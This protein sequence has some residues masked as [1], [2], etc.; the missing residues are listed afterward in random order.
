[1]PKKSSST[2]KLIDLD[3]RLK[4][5]L[6]DYQNLKKR[7]EKEKQAYQKFV[8]A[9]ILDKFLTVLDDLQRAYQHLKDPGLKLALDQFISTLESEGV[10]EIKLLNT[11]FDPHLAD[12]TE[13]VEGPK[14][15]IITI[16]K[17]G[18]TLHDQ[19][20][21]PAQVKVGKGEK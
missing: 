11:K 16:I 18:Y 1:M 4:R 17:K 9:S 6:A 5:A 15:K 7:H 14:N 2:S 19:V 8:S 12:C 21:R 10:K 3:N 13:S 20:L